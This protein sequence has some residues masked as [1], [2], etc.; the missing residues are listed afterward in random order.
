V[1]LLEAL[2][3]AELRELDA[4]MHAAQAE[5]SAAWPATWISSGINEDVT[6]TRREVNAVYP[7]GEGSADGQP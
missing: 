6:D 3:P 5:M 2:T 4:R 7:F 1:K